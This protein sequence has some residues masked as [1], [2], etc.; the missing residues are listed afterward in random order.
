VS[1][2]RVRRLLC[3]ADRLP[4]DLRAW[5]V[6]GLLGWQQGQSLE[7][8]LGLDNSDARGMD[9]SERD[10][11]IVHCI[12]AAPGESHAA[13]IAFFVECMSGQIEHHDDTAQRFIRI[14]HNSRVY[15]PGAIRHLRRILQG[16]RCDGWRFQG[17]SAPLCPSASRFNT[18]GTLNQNRNPKY[19]PPR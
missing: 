15:V 19:E 14:L 1:A 7:G 16:R 12:N 8:A 5:L 4:D 17:T 10:A 3:E 13:R 9:L 6:A 18:R 11:M 2:E